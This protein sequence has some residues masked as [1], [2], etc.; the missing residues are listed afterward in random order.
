LSGWGGGILSVNINSNMGI[1]FQEPSSSEAK[2]NNAKSNLCFVKLYW[3]NF[4]VSHP[5]IL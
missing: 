5:H 1:T 2:R 3:K 4:S